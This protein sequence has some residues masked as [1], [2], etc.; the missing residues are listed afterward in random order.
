M[1]KTVK[2]KEQNRHS[3]MWQVLS[4]FQEEGGSAGLSVCRVKNKFAS[5]VKAEDGYRDISIS[6]LYQDES[7]LFIIGEVC[8]D[9]TAPACQCAHTATLT[10]SRSDLP[11]HIRACI[12]ASLLQLS[13]HSFLYSGSLDSLPHNS[14]ASLHL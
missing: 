14:I 5:G 1:A 3:M 2:S 12:K 6:V 10:H 8:L 4:C 9:P 11:A 13:G 7:G